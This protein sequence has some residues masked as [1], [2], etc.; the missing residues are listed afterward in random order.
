[1]VCSRGLTW[2]AA[3]V[4]AAAGLACESARPTPAAEADAFDKAAAM[5][6]LQGRGGIGAALVHCREIVAALA[7]EGSTIDPTRT[8]GENADAIAAQAAK[9]KP[10][11]AGVGVTHVPGTTSVSLMLPSSKCAL[12]QST[13]S[14]V[15]DVTV[16]VK[17]GAATV[18][19]ALKS[20]KVRGHTLDGT[21][22]V[23]TGDGKALAWSASLTFDGH[24]WTWS[25]TPKL[26]SN[27]QGVTFDGQGTVQKAGGAVVGVHIAGLHHS[28]LACYANAGTITQTFKVALTAPKAKAGTELDATASAT[29]DAE[30]PRDG[31]VDVK[32]TVGKLPPVDQKDV[33]LPPYGDCPD[34]TAP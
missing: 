2:V 34:G 17:D 15:I 8:A 26:D 18:A 32:L 19:I 11:C 12:A 25:G 33:V 7:V 30:S 6:A 20:V 13:V 31:T 14:G 29:F 10:S 5:T 3:V 9:L 1:M 16:A 4:A 21:L 24:A 28:L 23:T 22:T 27:G